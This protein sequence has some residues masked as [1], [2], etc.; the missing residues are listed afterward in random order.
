MTTQLFIKVREL[1]AEKKFTELDQL[2][3]EKPVKFNWVKDV[4]EAINLQEHPDAK[5][6]V[7]TNGSET[8]EYSFR[9]ISLESNQLLNLLRR[10]GAVK[11]DNI[12]SLIPLLPE[13]WLFYLTAI[14]GGYCLIPAAVA[15]N[16]QDIV[17]RFKK[18]MPAIVVADL[19]NAEKMEEAEKIINKNISL[20]ILAKGTRPGWVSMDEIFNEPI[21]AESAETLPDDPLFLFFTSGTTGMPKIVT[22][23]HLS[24][25]LGHLTTSAWIGLAHGDLHYNISQP[26]WAKF[27]W[28]CIFAP[29][30]SGAAVF[31]YQ[32]EG[33]F[34]AQDHLYMIEK[35][36]VTALCCPPTVLRLF[37]QE[38]LLAYRFSLTK[39]VSAGEPL[40][41]QIIDDWLKGTGLTIRDGYGQTESTCMVGNLPNAQLKYGSMGKPTFLYDIVIADENGNILPHTEEGSLAVR[42]HSGKPNGIFSGYFNDP[43]KRAE[44]FKHGLYY[45]GD[46]A[47]RDED[48]Y[49]W[50]VSRD[51]DVI[52]S[53]DYRVG[54]FEVESVLQEH[55]SIL[56]SAVVASPHPIK[57]YEIK[58]F[59]I[60]VK[61]FTAGD[62]L[63]DEIFSF[64]RKNLASY[65]IPRIIEFVDELPKTISGKIRRGELR[66]NEAQQKSKGNK[67]NNE[68]FYKI[69][70]Q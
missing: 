11:Q 56:E 32:F 55:S 47:Y 9:K 41:P 3:I 38:N 13:N 27:A 66:T 40:N 51:D 53:S 54:P 6:L 30:S 29:W 36:K 1:I 26:G 17:Y 24:Y 65:K 16:V 20:R 58:A 14:K 23:T 25:P 61:G 42:M 33:R 31:V 37:I 45:S 69:S 10:H 28:S 2:D 19:N 43:G 64:A 67:S 5:A 4:F 52:K 48:G 62:D 34:I 60:L 44:V 63:A 39:C 22:H 12:F 46:R 35:Y 57:G 49:I 8:R 50:F 15:L 59:V 18:V 7:W 68:F 70:Q 21:E